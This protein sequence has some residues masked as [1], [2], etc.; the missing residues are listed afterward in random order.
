MITNEDINLTFNRFRGVQSFQGDI[1]VLT[2]MTHY[3]LMDASYDNFNKHVRTLPL[4]HEEKMVAS[5]ISRAYDSF[6]TRFLTPFSLEQREYL[7]DKSDELRAFIA[8]DVDRA[9]FAMMDCC[10]DETTD[11]Q[12]KIADLWLSNRFA[13]EA[14][15]FY[16]RTWKKDGF[17]LRGIL[18]TKADTDRDI[19]AVLKH[20][21]TL[22][23]MLYGGGEDVTPKHYEKFQA[24]LAAL[25]RKICAWINEDYKQEMEKRD[26]Q[27]N[28][29][30]PA[31][32]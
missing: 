23:E 10:D 5:K 3:F 22:T 21:I 11:V 17:K 6:F 15:S 12:I 18:F 28:T 7:G 27:P 1:N 20:S 24:C 26:E 32:A 25:T 16:Q 30:S 9:R 8:N 19:D 2:A 14:Q 4:R 29:H 13:S 31:S